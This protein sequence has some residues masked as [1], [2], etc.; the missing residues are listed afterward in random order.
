MNARKT[1]KINLKKEKVDNKKR[2]PKSQSNDVS[3]EKN[4]N[5]EIA[6]AKYGFIFVFAALIIYLVYFNIFVA[7]DIIDNT[8]N[9]RI[10]ALANRVVRGDIL[11]SNGYVLA[12]TVTKND[13][14]EV[15]LYPYGN[16]FA[17][18]IG[19][20]SHGKSGL[21]SFC[22]Y[23]LLSADSDIINDLTLDLTGDKLQGNKVVT[24]LNADVQKIVYSV[25]GDYTGAAILMDANTGKIISMVSKPDFDPNMA[26]SEYDSWASLDS[27]DSVLLNRAIHGS[28]P[29]GSTFK[30]VILLEYIREHSID[31]E[32]SYEC[33]G[34]NMVN[35]Y[36]L[37]CYDNRVHGN[38]DL[39][40][41]FA[42][43]CNGAFATIG[44]ELDIRRLKA[45]AGDLLFNVDYE[46]ELK[47]NTS[48]FLLEENSEINEI[49]ATSIGQGKTTVTP[50]HNL[51][52]MSAVANNGT[53]PI[54][55]L[56]DRIID[57][58]DKIV[59]EHKLQYYDRFMS[60]TEAQELQKYLLAVTTIGTADQLHNT[61]YKVYGKT[62][63]AQFDSSDKHHSLF[64]GYAEIG[65][66][67]I[68]ISVV[69]EGGRD[70]FTIAADITR[71]I[72][73]KIYTNLT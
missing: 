19:I 29:P 53:A 72:L 4:K 8:Y 58:N 62:G 14:T 22:N 28:Y 6:F 55:Y 31:G 48:K 10:D 21:E 38:E 50:L 3:I 39:L 49:I 17:H 59:S 71:Q 2:T 54:P 32:F 67:K 5:R 27:K 66:Q 7:P 12:T 37:S 44:C 68:A 15:R 57:S 56:V 51:I 11:D 30:M 41:S 26:L 40:H 60:D 47:H 23:Q 34:S 45:L 70:K 36:K 61:P 73:D 18:V 20:N 64:M 16:M 52:L 24:T 1:E 25:M 43:S 69:I 13:G 9:K 42:N 33:K 63:S 65:E 35:N 46:F